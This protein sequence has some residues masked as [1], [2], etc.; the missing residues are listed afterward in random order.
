MWGTWVLGRC[1]RETGHRSWT[2]THETKGNSELTEGPRE[3]DASCCQPHF[4]LGTGHR[5]P[6]LQADIW[7]RENK[8][9]LEVRLDPIPPTD[10]DAGIRSRCERIWCGFLAHGFALLYQITWNR[11]AN[12]F[13]LW[14]C[15]PGVT[16][17]GPLLSLQEVRRFPNTPP[18]PGENSNSSPN[19]TSRKQTSHA[20]LLLSHCLPNHI[21]QRL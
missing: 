4:M 7:R 6:W 3:A 5:Q 16:A 12:Y 1:K 9:G 18:G 8:K 14:K 20:R 11:K 21:N 13:S 15:F 2:R 10:T 17:D 19:A